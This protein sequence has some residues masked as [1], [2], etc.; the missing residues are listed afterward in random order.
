MKDTFKNITILPSLKNLDSI[1]VPVGLCLLFK[2]LVQRNKSLPSVLL[3]L[4]AGQYSR[5]FEIMGVTKE[6]PLSQRVTE[7]PGTPMGQEFSDL[8]IVFGRFPGEK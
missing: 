7:V 6:V 8:E 4:Q 3:M 5:D 1:K 2:N